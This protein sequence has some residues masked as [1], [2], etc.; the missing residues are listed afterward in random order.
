MANAKYVSTRGEGEPVTFLKAVLEGQ[1]PDGGLF[2]P[3]AI[4]DVADKLESWKELPFNTLAFEIIKLYA[5]D[6]PADE[7]KKIVDTSY[8]TFDCPEVVPVK[9]LKDLDILE[10]WH[11]PTLA[12]K[13]VALQ[14]LANV[15]QYALKK[16]D[17]VLNILGATSGDTGSAAIHAIRGKE[18]MKVFIMHPDGKT[19]PMQRLQMVTVEDENVFNIAIDGSFDDCQ[20]IMKSTFNELDFKY[21]YSLGTINSINFAR[22]LA[23]I[24]YY[25]SAYFQV[26]SEGQKLNFSVPTGNFG[27]VFAGFLAKKMGLPIDKLIVATN[28]NDILERFFRTGEYKK[29]AVEFTISPSMDIQV[30]SNFER[31]L[32]YRF[33]GDSA[34][35]RKALKQFTDDGVTTV[36]LVD[37]VVDPTFLAGRGGTPEVMASIKKYKEEED[38]VL[39][40]HTAVGVYVAE[41]LGLSNRTVCLAT[42]HPAKFP[43]SIEEAIGTAATHPSLEKLKGKPEKYE[44]LGND[45]QAVMAFMSTAIDA[46]DTKKK[47]DTEHCTDS[48]AIL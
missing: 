1:A 25:F 9:K 44:K 38:Y 8:G 48:C 37:G 18:R 26:A 7:L 23:Q 47:V 36:P 33:D 2:V 39:D 16:E 46:A 13:D 40:P 17:R 12:F 3:V 22:I 43:S 15:F 19:S 20:K 21:K 35:V 27:D 41:R 45:Q 31:Y 14:F 34:A 5:D 28:E 24:T 10:L 42:A 6:I 11:G 29:G 4:P 32:Y 30:A